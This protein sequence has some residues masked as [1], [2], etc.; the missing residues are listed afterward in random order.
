MTGGRARGPGQNDMQPGDAVLI[1]I[2]R[3]VQSGRS[4]DM[5]TGG[6]EATDA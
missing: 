3:V 4:G 5:I 1:T 2:D 6:A